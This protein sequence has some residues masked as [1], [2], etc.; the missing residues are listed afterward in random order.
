MD[1]VLVRRIFGALFASRVCR[2]HF[3]KVSDPGR[4]E[5]FVDLDEI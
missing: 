3:L 1:Y 5:D 4:V 2:V